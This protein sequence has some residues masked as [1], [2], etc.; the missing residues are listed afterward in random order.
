[1]SE[2]KNKS[3]IN[4]ES[5][6]P[7][8]RSGKGPNRYHNSLD[9]GERLAYQGDAADMKEQSSLS[10]RVVNISAQLRSRK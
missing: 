1:L 4:P 5:E 6:R 9:L 7:H 2:I 3:S 8:G 10:P